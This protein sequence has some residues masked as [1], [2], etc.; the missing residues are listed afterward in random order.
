MHRK[1]QDYGQ[2]G[3]QVQEALLGLTMGASASVQPNGHTLSTQ[4]GSLRC[5]SSPT[6]QQQHVSKQHKRVTPS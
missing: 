2:Y 6:K 1:C 3:D 4:T 5:L